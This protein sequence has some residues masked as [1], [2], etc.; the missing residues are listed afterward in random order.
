MDKVGLR[1]RTRRAVRTEIAATGMR[2]FLEHGFDAVTMDQIAAA[3]DI[4]RRSL[5]RYF[6]TKED[7][8]V[9]NLVDLAHSAVAVVRSRPESESPWVVLRAALEVYVSEPAHSAEWAYDLA[10]MIHGTPSLRARR[11]EKQ[12]IWIS[13]LAPEIEHRLTGDDTDLRALAIV[14]AALACLDAATEI[15]VRRGGGT[16]IEDLY[17]A[18]IAA[19]RQA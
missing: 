1:E 8:V 14:S 16:S 12:Q 18:A 19:I 2:L 4:S 17:D 15:W 5:F 6:D 10:R 7:I 11:L 3:A 9:G 13:L